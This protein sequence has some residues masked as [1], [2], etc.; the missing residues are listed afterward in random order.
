MALLDVAPPV[1]VLRRASLVTVAIGA[2]HRR[3]PSLDTPYPIA[4][5]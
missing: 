5:I 2:L 4:A 1:D 3:G